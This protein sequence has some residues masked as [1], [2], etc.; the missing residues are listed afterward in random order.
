[1]IAAATTPTAVTFTGAPQT[2]G[3]RSTWTI[4]YTASATGALKTGD[5]ISIGFST[6]FSIPANP[7][8]TLTG[9]YATCS[10][11]A[12]TTA[13]TSGATVLV[14]LANN[15]GTCALAN[16]ASGALT[17]AGITN[18]PASRRSPPPT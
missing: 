18:P 9:A 6:G 10:A 17:L 11:T 14:T 1:M 4:G 7:T 15:G 3:A 5:T 12:V 16:S 2:Q 8:V 13:T